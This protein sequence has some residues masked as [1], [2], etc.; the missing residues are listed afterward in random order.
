MVA[1]VSDQEEVRSELTQ[2]PSPCF[3]PGGGAVRQ[4]V[5]GPCPPPSPGTLQDGALPR[6][7]ALPRVLL[8]G[9]FRSRGHGAALSAHPFLSSAEAPRLACNTDS[10]PILAEWETA[11]HPTGILDVVGEARSSHPKPHQLQEG[12]GKCNSHTS[13]MHTLKHVLSRRPASS[14][15]GPDSRARPPGRRRW[16]PGGL[17][18]SEQAASSCSSRP[19]SR[20]VSTTRPNAPSE[21]SFHGWPTSFKT[22]AVL[23]GK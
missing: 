21:G 3:S 18:P 9:H 20:S 23:E 1:I 2:A 7:R 22:P 5:S 17:D 8:A 14:S 6:D 10:Q 13:Q 15:Q 16:V 4:L 12:N 19:V 11:E